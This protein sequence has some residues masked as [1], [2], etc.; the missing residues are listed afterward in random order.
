M[1]SSLEST[2]NPYMLKF[3]FGREA[4]GIVTVNNFLLCF[5]F[6][7]DSLCDVYVA[8]FQ[9]YKFSEHLISLL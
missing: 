8:I 9:F 2:E 5:W 1:K 3:F 6:K 4:E 7:A